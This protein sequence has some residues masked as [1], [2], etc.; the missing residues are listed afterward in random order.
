MA[1]SSSHSEAQILENYRVA[2]TNVETQP[3][4]ALIM[5]DFG[6]DTTKFAEG[7]ALLDITRQ[8]FDFNKQ[9]TQE[10]VIARAAFDEKTSALYAVYSPHRKKAK[11]A[12]SKQRRNIV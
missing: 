7:K 5:A 12:L 8:K 10:T 4:I 9:E 3:E 2:L 6:Y 1:T 11:V